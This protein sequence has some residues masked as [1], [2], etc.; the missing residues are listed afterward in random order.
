MTTP[1]VRTARCSC[2]KV[3]LEASGAPIVSLVC[4]CDD[5]QA[6]AWLIEA[7]PGALPVLGSDG[8]S[9]CVLYRRDRFRVVAGA[10][11][12]RGLRIRPDTA[13]ER[14]VATCCNT[15]MHMRFDSGPFWI[16]VY[17][18][19]FG[20]DAPP[21]E[22]RVSTR[23]APDPTAIPSDLPQHRGVSLKFAVRLAG[24]MVGM[25]LRH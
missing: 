5:C 4:Y 23:F 7:L 18:D 9:A 25:M 24:A 19:R 3:E 1:S 21:L 15:A 20:R 8:G 13:T 17:W 6:G 16:P 2:G 11:S 12:L 14:V 10:D 22:M